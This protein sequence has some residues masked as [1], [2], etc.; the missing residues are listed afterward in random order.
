MGGG[1]ARMSRGWKDKPE[2]LYLGAR[3][4]VGSWRLSDRQ[5]R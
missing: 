1:W 3:R 5:V 4:R 2:E